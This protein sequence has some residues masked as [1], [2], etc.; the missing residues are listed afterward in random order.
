[1]IPAS[2]TFKTEVEKIPLAVLVAVIVVVPDPP[3]VASPLAVSMS[4]TF[5]DDELHT[6]LTGPVVALL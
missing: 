4:A 6:T 3:G 2:S 5:A 1:M